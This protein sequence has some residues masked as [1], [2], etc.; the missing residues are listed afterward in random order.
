MSVALVTGGGRRIGRIIALALAGAGHAVIVHHNRSA[1][2]AESVAAEIRASG[3]RAGVAS[4]DLG[5]AAETEALMARAA[6]AFGPPSVLVNNASLFLHDAVD[7][8]EVGQW[9]RQLAA[10]LRAPAIL[11]RDLAR[12]LPDGGRGAV[13]NILDCKLADLTPDFFSYSAAKAALGAVTE[14]Q[15]RALAP[16]IRVNGIAPGLVL[17]SGNQSEARFQAIHDNNILRRGTRPDDIA[18]AVLYLL[19]AEA[20]TGQILFVD[21]GDRFTEG[22]HDPEIGG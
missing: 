13:V 22:R 21:G 19:G 6:Q 4:A 1:L 17:R 2:A 8:F 18:D 3:G 14:L 5:D 11:V 16:R 12:M 20:V 10:N 15:A 9:D 7:S